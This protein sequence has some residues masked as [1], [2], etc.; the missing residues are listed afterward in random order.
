MRQLLILGTL[1]AARRP[2]LAALGDGW[3]L[4][5][6]S[7]WLS[8]QLD[9]AGLRHR[10]PCDYCPPASWPR[11]HAA[12]A[13][14]LARLARSTPVPPDPAWLDD[15]SHLLVDELGPS[16]F[17]ADAARR[18]LADGRPRAVHAQRLGAHPAAAAVDALA[19]GF[20]A[21]G[22]ACTAWPPAGRR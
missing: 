10:R 19:R 9:A 6:T 8:A 21:L 4:V 18:L 14:R 2:Q 5:S 3:C 15:W 22:W 17:W 20:A 7:P 1:P 16:L 12:T 13:R 11:R